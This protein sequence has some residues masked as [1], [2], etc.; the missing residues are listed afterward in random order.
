MITLLSITIGIMVTNFVTPND[1][2][3]PVAI[4]Q[5]AILSLAA[6]LLISNHWISSWHN[7]SLVLSSD[8]ISTPLIILSCWLAPL[9]LI[10]SKGHLNNTPIAS[11]RTFILLIIII[12]TALIVTF[13][14]LELILFYIAFETTLIPT[15]ILITRW[16]AQMER[17]QA[18][19]YFIFYTLFGSLP[20]LVSLIALYFS[21]NSLSIPNVELIWL[22]ENSMASLTI[23]WLLSILAFLVKMPIYGFHLWLPK[24]HVEAPV[25]GSMILAAILLKLGG[26]GLIRLISLFSTTSLSFSS[27]PLVVFCSWGAL[28]TSIICIR[29]TDL[30]ALI[31]Y[32]S[33]G[34]MSIVA[35]GIF[36]ETTWGL[37]GA[38][39]LMI[40]HG[41]VSSALF[42]LANTAYERNGTRTLAITRG[43][44]LI[45][46]LSTLWWLLLCAANLG[47]PPSPNLIGEIL[48]LSSLINWSIWLFPIL[49]IATVFGAIYS[50]MIFQLTQQGTPSA[51]LSNISLSFSREHLLAILHI[52]PLIAIIP[53][54]GLTLITWSK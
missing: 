30:K 13:A 18:G 52:I 39:M 43:L 14:S 54:P 50:L 7:L 10:A 21:S 3:W 41:L 47:L 46:P 23:W 24:A 22:P 27:L 11:Q 2:L 19:L 20:L 9:A 1:K 17:F 49:G 16:G 40:A 15:L 32:S 5:S 44:K 42:A 29:Q 25:A 33:V 4:S 26:Y 53:S 6:T 31:A 38:L 48:I 8:T 45:L 35:A 51:F 12:T 34:H 37:N 36:S 28:I